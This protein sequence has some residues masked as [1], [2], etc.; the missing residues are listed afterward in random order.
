[1]PRLQPL[2]IISHT[3]YVSWARACFVNL[4]SRTDVTTMLNRL[5]ARAA[6]LL[7]LPLLLLL[8][9]CGRNLT[10]H[11]FSF[12]GSLFSIFVVVVA[13]VA[14]IDLLGDRGRSP[15]NKIIWALIIIL[16]PL[17]GAILYYLIGR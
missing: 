17:L 11:L 4:L 2:C 7:M 13:V 8:T 14:L 6:P 3:R 9:G 10:D 5:F 1:M 12:P 15:V 16:F